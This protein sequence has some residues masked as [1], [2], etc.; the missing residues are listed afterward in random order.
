MKTFFQN[1]EDKLF[2]KIEQFVTNHIKEPIT[3]LDI[4]DVICMH[5]NSVC[6]LFKKHKNQKFVDYLTEKK[7]NHACELL[8]NTPDSIIGIAFECGY[9][10]S[11]FNR[12]FKKVTKTTPTKY[13]KSHSK[14]D[15]E[16]PLIIDN[17]LK[18]LTELSISH[19]SLQNC[20]FLFQNIGW[21]HQ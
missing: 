6:R 8:Q 9:S 4:A 11:A 2:D 15:P 5:P 20:A 13:R 21:V 1:N 14:S 18:Q 17:I 16:L 3:L 12:N 7:I 10:L 19:P